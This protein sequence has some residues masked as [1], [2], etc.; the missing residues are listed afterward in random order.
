LLSKLYERCS[1]AIT[2]NLSFSEW[3]G[4]FGDAK[5]TTA[6]LDRLRHHCHIVETGNG[7]FRFKAST[8]ATKGRKEGN[9]P[10]LKLDPHTINLPGSILSGKTGP[11]PRGNQHCALSFYP[12]FLIFARRA[13]KSW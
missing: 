7:S 8:A 3:A 9:K 6:M 10:W 13:K 4:V 1:V 2:T 11:I 5:M 12:E